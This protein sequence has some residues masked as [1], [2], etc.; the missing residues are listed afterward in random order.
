MKLTTKQKGSI[1]E[2][3]IASDLA[4]RGY[5]VMFPFGE[6][7]DWD[8]L[9]MRTGTFERVQVKYSTSDGQILKVRARCHSV[10]AGSVT[11]TVMYSQATID[12]LGVYD[13]TTDIC[14]YIPASQLTGSSGEMYLRLAEP[15]NKVPSI[16][17]A[18]DYRQI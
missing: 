15:K 2:L 14:Y 3:A 10:H 9:I 6:Y 5:Q 16:R 13:A 4:K 8:L 12:W 18:K 11:K 17:W 7:G 1:G